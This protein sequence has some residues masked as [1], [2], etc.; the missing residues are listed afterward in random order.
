MNAFVFCFRVHEEEIHPSQ[1]STWGGSWRFQR[2]LL[3]IN[4]P[5]DTAIRPDPID[6]YVTGIGTYGLTTASKSNPKSVLYK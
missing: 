2:S 4:L 6:N 3:R 1:A 5:G